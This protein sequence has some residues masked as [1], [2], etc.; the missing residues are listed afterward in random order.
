MNNSNK[1]ILN[2]KQVSNKRES[3]FKTIN[4]KETEKTFVKRIAGLDGEEQQKLLKLYSEII[5]DV[6]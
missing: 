4:L 1:K 5:K 2:K 6:K 3:I